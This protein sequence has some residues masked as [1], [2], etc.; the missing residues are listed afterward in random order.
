[1]TTRATEIYGLVDPFSNELRYVGKTQIGVAKRLRNH[2]L[3]SHLRPTRHSCCWI[4]GLIG[5]GAV[6]EVV[7]LETVQPT[8]DWAAA[9]QFWIAYFRTLGCRL[10]NLTEGGE[11]V[12]GYVF[13][14]SRKDF[15][16]A[17]FKG[18]EFTPE[19]RA[20]ISAAKRGGPPPQLSPESR[21]KQAASSSATKRARTSCYR[22]HPYTPDNVIDI[23]NGHRGCRE[24]KRYHGRLYWQRKAARA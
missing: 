10:T 11:G 20:K 14:Q 15:L 17:K 1:M 21:A 6:P 23:G 16:S 9:E 18:R 19:W 4:L 7:V 3:R 2:L 22:G 12:G 24:C 8:G 5:K 13:P